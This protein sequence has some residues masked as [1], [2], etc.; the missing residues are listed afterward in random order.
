MKKGLLIIAFA[1]ALAGSAM[2]EEVKTVSTFYGTKTSKNKKN[3]C[4]GATTRICGTIE[5]VSK[6][7][8]ITVT[9]V[10]KTVTDSKGNIISRTVS[11]TPKPTAKVQKQTTKKSVTHGKAVKSLNKNE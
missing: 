9:Q 7:Q 4:K 2:A 1:M 5:T 3:P 11:T 10:T 8:A 6:Q